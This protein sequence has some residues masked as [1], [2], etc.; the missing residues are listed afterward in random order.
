MR[1]G[2]MIVNDTKGMC[3]EAFA[4]SLNAYAYGSMRETLRTLV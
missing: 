4:V 3:K 1:Y 2:R